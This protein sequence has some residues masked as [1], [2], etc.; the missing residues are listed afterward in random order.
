MIKNDQLKCS[1]KKEKIGL[2]MGSTL[3][4]VSARLKVDA[5]DG[6]KRFVIALK[7]EGETE[8]RYLVA[9]DVSWRTFDIIQAYSLR[10]LVEF[11]LKTGSFM[12]DGGE[13]PNNLTKMDQ[14]EA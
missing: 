8:Y 12:K 4:V 3:T 14:A 11:F 9:T 6:K 7:Y 1:L 2:D 13:R 5:H 10:W